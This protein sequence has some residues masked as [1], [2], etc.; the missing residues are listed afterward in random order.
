MTGLALGE[1]GLIQR[2]LYT[3]TQIATYCE[4]H[5]ASTKI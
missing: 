1:S 4:I 2:D 5:A 3:A